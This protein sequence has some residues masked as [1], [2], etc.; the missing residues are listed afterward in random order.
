MEPRAT[1]AADEALVILAG[2]TASRGDKFHLRDY[3][4]RNTRFKVFLP[5][6]C[7]YFGIRFAARLL[8]AFLKQNRLKDFKRCHFICYIS[9]GFVLRC[10]S[11]AYLLPNLGR[12]V[13]LRSPLQER[14]PEC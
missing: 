11:T 5:N 6:L 8:C 7:Q 13:Y 9:G 2:I 1:A 12:I 4:R 14:V 3:Y 10:A